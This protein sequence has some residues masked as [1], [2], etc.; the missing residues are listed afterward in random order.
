MTASS[1][2]IEQLES[3][4]M[5]MEQLLQPWKT[6]IKITPYQS[7]QVHPFP[8]YPHELSVIFGVTHNI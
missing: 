1:A 8:L 4:E 5:L 7:L 3:S 6:A 2:C